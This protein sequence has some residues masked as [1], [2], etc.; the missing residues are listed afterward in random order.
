MKVNLV[1]Y[2][3]LDFDTDAGDKVQGTKIYYT[4]SPKNEGFEGLKVGDKFVS[5][6]LSQSIPFD[7][8][9]GNEVN[10]DFDDR[11]RIVDITD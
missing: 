3:K 11:G 4:Y 8:L 1:G 2:N 10:I 6:Q 5:K 9:I 7:I